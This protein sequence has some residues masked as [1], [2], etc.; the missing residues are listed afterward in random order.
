VTDDEK[1]LIF[2][3]NG[4]RVLASKGVAIA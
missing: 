1:A 3:G 2:S 4:R